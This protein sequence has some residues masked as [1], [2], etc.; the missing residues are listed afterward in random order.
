M[1]IQIDYSLLGNIHLP[2]VEEVEAVVTEV[3]TRRDVV[4]AR[5]V[6]AP[7][8]PTGKEVG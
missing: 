2:S 4:P 3:F 1:C 8:T 6:A 7:R 5:G